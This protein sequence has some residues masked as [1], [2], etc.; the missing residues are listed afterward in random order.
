MFAGG[1]QECECTASWII[2]ST[3]IPPTVVNTGAAAARDTSMGGGGNGGGNGGGTEKDQGRGEKGEGKS[4]TG[5]GYKGEEERE[6]DGDAVWHHLLLTVERRGRGGTSATISAFIDGVRL[7][8]SA[9]STAPPIMIRREDSGGGGGG[10]IRRGVSSQVRERV[11]FIIHCVVRLPCTPCT[12][13]LRN[14]IL[15]RAY[16]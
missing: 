8:S 10:K 9:P 4:R 2:P 7:T 15:H 16:L 3:L 6:V 5:G 14:D 12:S 1:G 11:I 13:A